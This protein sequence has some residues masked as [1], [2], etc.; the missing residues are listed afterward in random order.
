MEGSKIPM[1]IRFDTISHIMPYYAKTHKAFLLLSSLCSASRLKLEEFYDEF[2]TSMTER[3]LNLEIESDNSFSYFNL[4]NDLFGVSIQCEDKESVNALIKFIEN[5][6]DFKGWYFN[7]HY[8]HSKIKILDSF[9]VDIKF[10]KK[11]DT[12]IDF[13]KSTQVV[14]CKKDIYRSKLLY[15]SVTLDTNC[16]NTELFILN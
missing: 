16:N 9:S 8:M 12:Y 14:L 6:I 3:W 13:L 1:L 4:P 5:L 7:N 10:I 15:Q 11:L 2:I